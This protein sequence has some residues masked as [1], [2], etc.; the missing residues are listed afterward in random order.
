MGQEPEKKIIKEYEDGKTNRK[1][2]DV[3]FKHEDE[4]REK[5]RSLNEGKFSKDTEVHFSNRSNIQHFKL[6]DKI[7]TLIQ[8]ID[9]LTTCWGPVDSNWS[10]LFQMPIQPLLGLDIIHKSYFTI[11]Y[12]PKSQKIKVFYLQR[13]H[14]TYN[15][16]LNLSLF[17]VEKLLLCSK[18]LTLQRFPSS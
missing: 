8:F 4:E 9:R 2:V 16:D 13:S 11:K 1:T 14:S 18:G 5:E 7:P 12:V 15:T 3:D 6:H 10:S 17:Y